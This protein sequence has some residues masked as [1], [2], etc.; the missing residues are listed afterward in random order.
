MRYHLAGIL[1]LLAPLLLALAASAFSPAFR[2]A[3]A[4]VRPAPARPPPARQAS[5]LLA[6]G[7]PPFPASS[8]PEQAPED[9]DPDT[10]DGQDAPSAADGQDAPSAAGS[11]A[12]PALDPDW[13]RF[14]ANLVRRSAGDLTSLNITAATPPSPS[15]RWAFPSPLI[16]RGSVILGSVSSAA[17]AA[18]FALHQPYFHKS[19]ILLLEH[20][21]RFTKGI[22]LNR[23][24]SLTIDAEPP[25]PPRGVPP[26]PAPAPSLPLNFGGDVSGSSSAA[27]AVVL[28]H[29]LK[30][31]EAA[32]LSLPIV[33]GIS[34]T[35]LAHASSLMAAGLAGPRDFFVFEGYAGWGPGQLEGEIERKSWHVVQADEALLLG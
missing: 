20:G 9:P 11:D 6:S 22:I 24:T 30:S 26:P 19:I 5:A 29:A 2:P 10:P 18:S 7:D 25:T 23:P 15:D 33:P 35:S 13:R 34:Y 3:P 21:P 27:P 1:L 4:P 12:P 32:R 17:N 16:E 8:S 14:R 31:A 28:L